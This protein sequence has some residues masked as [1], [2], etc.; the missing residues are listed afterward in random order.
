MVASM[1]FYQIF[2]LCSRTCN[3]HCDFKFY[4]QGATKECYEQ[5]ELNNSLVYYIFTFAAAM[6]QTAERQA[7]MI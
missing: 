7:L 4:I 1:A 6:E 5:I 2:H 3:D